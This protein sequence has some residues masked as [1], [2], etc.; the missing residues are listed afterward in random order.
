MVH[1][2]ADSACAY[3][4]PPLGGLHVIGLTND[5][6]MWHTINWINSWQQRTWQ[7]WGNVSGTVDLN[8]GAFKNVACATGGDGEQLHV[9]GL[10]NDGNMWHTIR[11]PGSWQTWG[12]VSGTVDLNPG[13]FK[14][15]ACASIPHGFGQTFIHVIGLTNDGNMWHTI[16]FPGSWQTWGNVSGT[17][18]LN[19]GAFKNVAC[20]TFLPGIGTAKLHVIGLTNDGNMWHTIRSDNSNNWQTWGNVSGTVDLNPGA[21]KNVACAIVGSNLNVI[22]LTN[23]GNMWHTIRFERSWQEWRDV[24]GLLDVG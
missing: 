7:T 21:F 1:F 23:D 17:V 19:P 10:T 8:P 9:I 15:V 22:G 4:P 3:L 6:N 14:N 16:R 11:F 5:G 20:A 2:F 12:N 18:D 24:S 13:A